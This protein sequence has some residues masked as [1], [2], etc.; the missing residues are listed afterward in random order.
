[1]PPDDL[2][3]L[4]GCVSRNRVLFSPTLSEDRASIQ[5][6]GMKS[7]GTW[8]DLIPSQ[9]ASNSRQ[10]TARFP[11]PD[12]LCTPQ[13]YPLNM[14]YS[15]SV[16]FGKNGLDDEKSPQYSPVHA[17]SVRHHTM[18]DSSS[19]RLCPVSWSIPGRLN[20]PVLKPLRMVDHMTHSRSSCSCASYTSER[21]PTEQRHFINVPVVRTNSLDGPSS[22]SF[23]SHKHHGKGQYACTFILNVYVYM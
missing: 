5:L 7:T 10:T 4:R 1:M 17:S 12:D 9:D 18:E 22:F 15:V 19:H 23:H 3:V 21:T 13:E 2:S 20:S 11:S 14:Q 8:P 6:G 16:Q